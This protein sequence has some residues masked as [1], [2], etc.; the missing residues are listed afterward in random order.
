MQ[1][2]VYVPLLQVRL[3]ILC[4]AGDRLL[5]A[6]GFWVLQLGYTQGKCWQMSPQ[7]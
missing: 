4:S 7:Q 5:Q 6:D 1:V 3:L 2:Q